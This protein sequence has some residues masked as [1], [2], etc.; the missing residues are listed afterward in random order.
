MF[1][2]ENCSVHLMGLGPNPMALQKA[3][4]AQEQ[5][6]FFNAFSMLYIHTKASIL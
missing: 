6:L 1:W 5:Q 2:L 3:T 4:F